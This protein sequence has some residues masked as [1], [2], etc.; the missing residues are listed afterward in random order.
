MITTFTACSLIVLGTLVMILVITG[1]I[2]GVYSLVDAVFDGYRKEGRRQECIRMRERYDY[3][4]C[5][6][7]DAPAKK[8]IRD[9]SKDGIDIDTVVREYNEGRV[10]QR[11]NFRAIT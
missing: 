9:L 11:R 8:L 10:A 1:C 6:F 2:L 4:A 7:S 3:Y 5:H